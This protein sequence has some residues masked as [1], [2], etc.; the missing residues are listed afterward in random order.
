MRGEKWQIKFQSTLLM[1]GAT[2]YGQSGSAYIPIS[3]HAPHARS[4]CSCSLAN[5]IRKISIHAPHARS[6]K[7]LAY[8][9]RGRA[10][11]IHAP[12][13]RSDG[14]QGSM[15]SYNFISIH[16]PHARSDY[17]DNFWITPILDFNPR[18]SCEERLISTTFLSAGRYFNPRSSCEERP[19]HDMA[20]WPKAYFNPRSSCEERQLPLWDDS[21]DL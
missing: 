9:A 20:H 16:A 5:L 21:S 19:R 6:D 13:A 11:S 14:E 3:I 17:S 12:H 7:Y 8:V 15:A 18:S 2:G 1:R 10:I 4:D